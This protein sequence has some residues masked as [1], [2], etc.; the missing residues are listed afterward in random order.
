LWYKRLSPSHLIKQLRAFE[1]LAHLE[2][3]VWSLQKILKESRFKIFMSYPRNFRRLSATF[4]ALTF[5][6]FDQSITR[7]L[8]ALFIAAFILIQPTVLMAQRGKVAEKA[9]PVSEGITPANPDTGTGSVSLTTIGSAATENFNTLSNTAGSTTNTT[10]PTGWYITESGGGARDNEQYAVDTG[11]STTGDIYSYGAAAATDRALGELR[12]GTL[13]PLFG[14]KFTNNT[15]V[16]ITSLD[17]SY[18]GEEWRFGGVHSTNPDRLDFQYSTD[19]T[20]LSTGTWIDA[21]SLDF[22]PPVTTGSAGALDGNAAANRTAISSTIPGLSIAN[23]AT[24]FIRFTDADATGA[25]DGIS[26][27]DFSITPQTAPVTPTLNI[28]DVTQ[29]EGNA[30][31]TTFTFAVTLSSPAGAGGV[32]FDIATADGTAQ[33]DNPVSEDNDYVAKSLTGQTIPSGSTGPYNFSV[34]VN[35]DAVNEANE[36]FFVNISNVTGAN[37]GDLQGLGTITNDDATLTPIHTIQG[38]GTASPLATTTV[39]TTGIVIGIKS[40]SS[41][42]FFIQDPSPDGDPNT[43]EGIF[44]FTGG[45]IPAAAVVGNLVQVNGTV[46]EF[47]FTSDPNSP[48]ITE[49]SGSPTTSLLSSGNPLP[50]AHTL[51][52]A[53]TT[54]PSGTTN[55]LDSLEE[56]EGMRVTVPSLTVVAPTQ[57]TITEPAATVSSNGVFYGV[58][59][60]VAR[61]FREPGV[62]VSD[63]TAMSLP[64]TIPR[65]DENP[66]R[67]RVDSDGQPGTTLVDVAAGAVLT[68]V[69]G[70][71]DYSFRTYTILPDTTIV[72]GVQPGAVP[73]PTPTSNEVTVASFNMERFF[74]TADDAGTSDPVLTTAAFNKRLDKASQIIRGVQRYPDVI[75]V[76]EMENLTTLQAVATKINGDAV[77]ID[78]LPNP[79]YVPY[80]VE[81]N[82]IGGIDVGFLVK[83]SRVTTVSVTQYNKNELFVNPDSSTSL[84]NDRPPLVL[85][86]TAPRPSG[87]TFAFTVIVNHL[88]SLGGVDDTTAGSNGWATEGDRVRAKRQKQAE[89]LANLIQGFQVANPTEK[90]LTLG[91]MN[92]FQVNDGFADVIGTIKGTP[93]PDNQTLVPGDGADLVNPDLTDLVDTLTPDQRYSYSFDGNAQVLDHIIANDDALAV[94]SRFAYA[95]DDADYAVKNYELANNLRLSDHD[96]PI[97]YLSLAATGGTLLITEF[98]LDGPGGPNDE[99][100]EI[101]NN[102]NIA[103]TVAASDASAG[104]GIAASDG[105]LRCTIPNGT[106]IPARGHFLC[107]NSVG[108][109]LGGYPS[110]N[111]PS[112]GELGDD[113]VMRRTSPKPRG[114]PFDDPQPNV[115]NATGD[116][117]YT[118]N[119]LDNAGI[120]LFNST[121]TFTLAT[122][123]DA[124]GSTSE[125]NTLYKEGTGYPALSGTSIEY[126]FLRDP[127]GKGGSLTT[128]GA[129][130][131]GGFPVDTDNNA[132]NFFFVDTNGTPLGAPRHLGAPGPE[133]LGS[134]IQRNS[135]FP[136]PNLDNT[137]SSSN[138][139][140][141]I[142]DF[143]SAPAQN[144][145]F[146]TLDIR[147]R[148]VNNT[149]AAITR[150][151]FRV[152]DIT[153][154]PV[155]SGYA[156]LR[157][158]TSTLVVVSGINDAATCFASNGIA[159]TPCTVNVQGLTLETPPTQPNGGGF[160]STVSAGTV[161][162]GT[163]LANGAS[164]NVR[165]LLGIQQT[166]TF[167]FY[168]NVEVLP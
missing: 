88:R 136:G 11:A 18:N 124:V 10:L 130:P 27:D 28:G 67:I 40:G 119:I 132:T 58:V 117:T 167:K 39:T 66:E 99:F 51:T 134:P 80:L 93:V 166:G 6:N 15:G 34:D 133:N 38:S 16:T 32:T 138:P 143:T 105:V 118:T 36:T 92:A 7:Q 103:H 157:V 164:I 156:D 123:L 82:D 74:D 57:G 26:A 53:E 89:S 55:P 107:V 65:F 90:I 120:A 115:P 168:V 159:T 165:F 12:S 9:K 137:V 35:G 149:G 111:G 60:G 146:G 43:S 102:T 100:I 139:P 108:Y 153:T 71:L 3:C 150:L 113:K 44:V 122:R 22:N 64:G 85:K 76:E 148:V 135:Q 29:A 50:A 96:Q 70:P 72:P 81:G 142:R 31:T 116:A 14:A 128:L 20:D 144:S 141:R 97:V 69:T 154:F 84:L 23:G 87:G 61:P 151:R 62:A 5:P 160:N 77:S 145:T 45:A 8:A 126:V 152:V 161:T 52:G 13:I 129:C 41:G 4:R 140:N 33:D 68:N 98:R 163:P 48:P 30:G 54:A 121:T 101:Y 91:D 75:G 155:P 47:V 158:R 59:T 17:V 131:S 109:S 104:Y 106:V 49:I 42:G 147:K 73:A 1:I 2:S 21:N 83:E 25:D 24:F 19:A 78:A 162:L 127:C 56:F 94:V 110:G 112:D 46:Q 95:R 63:A 114:I 86:A 125:A 79:N 37:N